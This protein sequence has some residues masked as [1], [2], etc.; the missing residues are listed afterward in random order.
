[1]RERTQRPA[2]TSRP[3]SRIRERTLR[4]NPEWFEEEHE[5]DAEPY[6]RSEPTN[7]GQ[8]TRE[9]VDRKRLWTNKKLKYMNHML[10]LAKKG[11]VGLG[12]AWRAGSSVPNRDLMNKRRQNGGL[13]P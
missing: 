5:D 13:M 6:R 4:A 1:M 2:A 11:E 3:R 9:R 7:F 8:M 10:F 12:V